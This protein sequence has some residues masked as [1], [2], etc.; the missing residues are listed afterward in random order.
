MDLCK[1]SDALGSPGTGLHRAR[2]PGTNTAAADYV[3]TLLA[4]WLISAMFAFPL[5]P[6]TVVLFICGS[7]LHLL[8]CVK[9][10]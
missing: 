8:F 5:V 1:Y 6:T 3:L 4:A 7:V 10:G 2:I 9:V